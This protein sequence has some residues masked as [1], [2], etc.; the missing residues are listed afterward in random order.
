MQRSS[1]TPSLII[2]RL[3]LCLASTMLTG[4]VSEELERRVGVLE[5]KTTKLELALSQF[6]LEHVARI[7]Q[8]REGLKADAAQV[9]ADREHLRVELNGKLEEAY[10]QVETVRKDIIAIVQRANGAT[11]KEI[12]DRVSLL[13]VLLGTILL[14]IEELEKRPQP[15]KK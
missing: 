11:V 15:L 12:D 6:D 13:D 4:C 3:F 1:P 10:R 14:R 2:S 5:E 9:K 7:A 8:S